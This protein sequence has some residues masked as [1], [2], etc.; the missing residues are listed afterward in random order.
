[1]PR[2]ELDVM[3]LDGDEARS[4]GLVEALR[5]MPG[6]RRLEHR[7]PLATSRRVAL[8]RIDVVIADVGTLHALAKPWGLGASGLPI[9]VA[10]ADTNDEAMRAFTAGARVCVSLPITPERLGSA[11]RHLARLVELYRLAALREQV[12]LA[13]RRDGRPALDAAAGAPS[14]VPAMP[15]RL[16]IRA[17]NGGEICLLLDEVEYLR[18]FGN[19]VTIWTADRAHRTRSTL[20]SVLG[21]LSPGTFLRIHRSIIVNRARVD[22][23]VRDRPGGGTVIMRSGLRLCVS[24]PFRAALVSALA[25]RADAHIV[26]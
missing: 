15:E 10:L 24:R 23:F 8:D 20:Q 11:I 14:A 22:R 12:E 16:W 4:A 17:A 26:G 1:M 19:H 3:L 5:A 9:P 18:A 13:L 25:H 7:P 21:Q 6:I 2:V